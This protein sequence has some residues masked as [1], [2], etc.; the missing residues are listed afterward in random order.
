MKLCTHTTYLI[1]R[2]IIEIFVSNFH[3][4]HITI[5]LIFQL[6]P[7]TPGTNKKM[8]EIFKMTFALWGA[9]A[10]KEG[11]PKNPREWTQQDVKTWLE[12]CIGEFQ[13][14]TTIEKLFN[15][16]QVSPII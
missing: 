9:Q 6:P 2:I 16:Y 14:D 13:F 12:W 15:D 4:R 1:N 7:L 5:F 11:I 10:Q 8:D 3:K